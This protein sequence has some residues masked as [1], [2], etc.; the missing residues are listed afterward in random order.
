ELINDIKNHN[1]FL[2]MMKASAVED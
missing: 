1:P 2:E